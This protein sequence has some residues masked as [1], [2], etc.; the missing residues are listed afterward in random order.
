MEGGD[1]QGRKGVF[2]RKELKIR[3]SLP[4]Y[5]ATRDVDTVPD[6]LCKKPKVVLCPLD[7]R[8]DRLVML[9]VDTK[10][11]PW[12][13]MVLLLQETNGCWCS[14]ECWHRPEHGCL[15]NLWSWEQL[16]TKDRRIKHFWQCL[17]ITPKLGKGNNSSSLLWDHRKKCAGTL[18]EGGS[19]QFWTHCSQHQ[20]D[21]GSSELTAHF[22]AH[23]TRWIK[24][25][26]NSLLTSLLTAPGGSRQFW[27]HGSL[28]FLTS[29]LIAPGQLTCAAF[30]RGAPV[31][32]CMTSAVKPNSSSPSFVFSLAAGREKNTVLDND[33]FRC[34]NKEE[35]SRRQNTI[36]H[37]ITCTLLDT[38]SPVFWHSRP[39]A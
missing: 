24:T 11:T 1:V 23:S 27:T 34:E 26:L 28:L 3:L 18:F 16:K 32:Y 5:Q 39:T 6:Y 37:R 14:V 21:Q 4:K 15:L 22:T 17:N 9:Q 13:W 31:E 25:V 30:S 2:L 35:N 10:I 20:V 12:K 19:R 8:A 29:L 38:S 36:S 33:V 7:S